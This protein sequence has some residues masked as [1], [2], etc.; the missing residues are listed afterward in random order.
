[1]DIFKGGV[2]QSYSLGA[3]DS[4]YCYGAFEEQFLV[5]FSLLL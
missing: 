4:T 3:I 2:F 1:M 5:S